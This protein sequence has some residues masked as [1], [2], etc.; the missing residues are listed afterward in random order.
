MVDISTAGGLGHNET[1]YPKS[2][3]TKQS[4]G[5]P[6]TA[7][8]RTTGYTP[9]VEN[10]KY[11][12]KNVTVP[13]NEITEAG[14]YYFHATGWLCRV[15]GDVLALGRHLRIMPGA[16][17]DVDPDIFSGQTFGRFKAKPDPA[18]NGPIR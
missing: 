16:Q 3:N 11:V 14:A 12:W 8:K 2:S 17:P 13:F 6:A 4:Q 15:P 9:N 1:I 5:V 10:T 18:Y 7:T